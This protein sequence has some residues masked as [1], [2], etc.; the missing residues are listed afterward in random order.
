[1]NK[2]KVIIMGATRITYE[3]QEIGVITLKDVLALL[4]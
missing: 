1:M 2:K 4:P 3:L